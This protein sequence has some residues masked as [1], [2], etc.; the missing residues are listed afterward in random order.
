MPGHNLQRDTLLGE[1]FKFRFGLP[2]GP[3]AQHLQRYPVTNLED[4]DKFQSPTDQIEHDA[5]MA[6]L[7]NFE[8]TCDPTQGQRHIVLPQ[9]AHEHG[10]AFLRFRHA[11]TGLI[12]HPEEA[13]FKPYD[14]GQ[15]YFCIRHDAGLPSRN[16]TVLSRDL[17]NKASPYLDTRSKT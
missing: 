9:H 15:R 16:S 13:V 1:R 10:P 14:F 7:G 6:I 5:I 4:R 2:G 12:K 11:E 8:L 17:V 3:P